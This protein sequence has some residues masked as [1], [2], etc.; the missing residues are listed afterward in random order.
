MDG[1]CLQITS[2]VCIL[3]KGVESNQLKQNNEQYL[4]GLFKSVTTNL[5]T[6]NT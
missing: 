2:Q 5:S 4:V 3:S 1:R 6:F